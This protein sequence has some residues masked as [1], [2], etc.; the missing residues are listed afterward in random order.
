MLALPL[1]AA[2]PPV[3]AAPRK[4]V[5]SRPPG[6]VMLAGLL[7]AIP[8]MF[9]ISHVKHGRPAYP[10]SIARLPHGVALFL[11]RQ[12]AAGRVFSHPNTAGYLRW[13]LDQRYRIFMDMEFPGI[14]IKYL[15][16]A[17]NAFRDPDA[18]RELLA[19]YDPPF[20]SAPI[21]SRGFARLAAEL[22]DFQMVFFDD[23]EVL[24][25]NRRHVPA[26]AEEHAVRHL[27]PFAMHRQLAAGIPED[28]EAQQQ[29]F[30]EARRM[31]AIHPSG[32][33]LNEL[34][35]QVCLHQG[36]AT[37]A[38]RHAA[39]LVQ[40]YPD[41][42]SGYWH[43]GNALGAL[44]QDQAAIASYRRALVN[45]D[46]NERPQIFRSL[47]QLYLRGN[48]PG[49]AYRALTNG[50]DVIAPSTSPDDILQVGWAAA[51]SGK[52]REARAIF[53]FLLT[54]R[55][56]ALTPEMAATVKAELAKLETN[57]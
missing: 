56:D 23:S 14:P 42:P 22:P 5:P 3:L 41:V 54:Y 26:L 47:G 6:T 7:M 25:V 46:R 38:H 4:A 12:D 29:A 20:I 33:L 43:L 37:G 36:D 2:H 16:A 39:I 17:R 53:S 27:D 11:N 45:A 10:F 52:L 48:Q 40:H 51:G 44:G 50:I 19:Q 24:Y 13:M 34:M 28:A 15:H 49:P 32:R 31:L 1:V 21:D 18:L 8:A 35:T 9:L 30:A 57:P 55:A